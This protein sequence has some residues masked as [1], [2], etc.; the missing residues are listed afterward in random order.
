MAVA[1]EPMKRLALQTQVRTPL[2][3]IKVKQQV[4]VAVEP[5][6]LLALQTQVKTPP[7]LIKVKP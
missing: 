2:N 4:A 1:V 5:M 6:K 3:L 7:N